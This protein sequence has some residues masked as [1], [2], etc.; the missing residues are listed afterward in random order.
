[1]ECPWT[2]FI[3]PYMIMAEEGKN[4]GR[5]LNEISQEDS[6]IECGIEVAFGKPR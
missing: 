1:M 2:L 4:D 3:F 6:G 5:T